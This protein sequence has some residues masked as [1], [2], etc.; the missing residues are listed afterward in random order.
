MF[1]PIIAVVTGLSKIAGVVGCTSPAVGVIVHLL[2]SGLIGISYGLLFERESPDF[3]AGIA[4]G[5]LY[6]LVWWFAGRLTLF[7]ILQG[8]SFTWTHEAAADALPLLVGHLNLW[9]GYGGCFP[10]I[11]TAPSGLDV[12][13]PPFRGEARASPPTER[14]TCSSSLVVCGG[15]WRTAPNH[16]Y[17]IVL[18]FASSPWAALST[19]FYSSRCLTTPRVKSALVRRRLTN[20]SFLLATRMP[21]QRVPKR[22]T[23]AASAASKA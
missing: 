10:D 3:A 12:I 23:T 18:V 22:M 17:L 4:W 2:S 14:N 8:R 15:P 13:R 11:R 6:G 20:P 7:P 16:S 19:R 21:S 9:G 5:L 1:L